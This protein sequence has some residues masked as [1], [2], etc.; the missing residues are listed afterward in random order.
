MYNHHLIAIH[1][2]MLDMSK[3]GSLIASYEEIASKAKTSRRSVARGINEL[4]A[5][6]KLHKIHAKGRSITNIYEVKP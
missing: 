6:N 3:N 1:K 4:I 5:M 2:A